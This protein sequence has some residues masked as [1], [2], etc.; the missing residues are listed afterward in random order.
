MS[1]PQIESEP[2]KPYFDPEVKAILDV[3]PDRGAIRAETL[4]AAR[5]NR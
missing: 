4:E 1:E 5:T 2:I 3:G